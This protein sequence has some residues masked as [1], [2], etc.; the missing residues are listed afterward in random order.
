[1]VSMGQGSKQ[2]FAGSIYKV[3]VELLAAI[4]VM[5]R[6]EGG[7]EEDALVSLLVWLLAA[8]G[9]HQ[10]LTGALGGLSHGFSVGCSQHWQLAFPRL[11][12]WREMEQSRRQNS[13][14]R[15]R[16]DIPSLVRHSVR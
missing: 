8:S 12:D 10:L 3:A 5:S 6:F 4:A 1:M 11:R 9:S 14:K 2:S 7:G 15:L 16:G 13:C